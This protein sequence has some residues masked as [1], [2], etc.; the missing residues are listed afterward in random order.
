MNDSTFS[1]L[2]LCFYLDV[3]ESFQTGTALITNVFILYT[4]ECGLCIFIIM[5]IKAHIKWYV[6]LQWCFQQIEFLIKLITPCLQAPQ[7]RIP[8]LKTT[9]VLFVG[10]VFLTCVI[11]CSPAE[12]RFV[13]GEEPPVRP[14]T[15]LP[16]F[17]LLQKTFKA[18]LCHLVVR[19]SAEEGRNTVDTSA[20]PARGVDEW[21]D[22]GEPEQQQRQHQ[23]EQP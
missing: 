13:R 20:R 7:V 14:L 21:S 8:Q 16:D 5:Q 4:K 2:K 22:E 23:H 10:F 1:L 15:G 17:P 11:A 9:P 3:V 18:D 12:H 6:P 19:S